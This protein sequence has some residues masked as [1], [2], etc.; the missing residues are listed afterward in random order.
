MESRTEEAGGGCMCR[1]RAAGKEKG[2]CNAVKGGR[3]LQEMPGE[4]AAGRQRWR[5]EDKGA[6]LEAEEASVQER[7]GANLSLMRQG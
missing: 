1:E 5:E 3:N 7:A 4:V 6:L 2:V